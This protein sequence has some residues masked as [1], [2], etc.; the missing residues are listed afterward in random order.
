M[1]FKSSYTITE[2][3]SICMQICKD[4]DN[5]CMDKLIDIVDEER[6]M[7]DDKNLIHIDHIIK[8]VEQI[9]CDQ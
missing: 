5:L 7:Y 4:G 8:T 2:I 3:D 6:H 1:T 9:I